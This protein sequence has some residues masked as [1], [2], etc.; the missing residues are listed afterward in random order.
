MARRAIRCI[1][2][3]AWRTGWANLS[4]RR[5]AFR[6]RWT[7][8]GGTCGQPDHGV[9]PALPANAKS[10]SNGSVLSKKALG[11]GL[12]AVQH[13]DSIVSCTA[14][15]PHPDPRSSRV[16][17]LP[18]F[19]GEGAFI[20]KPGSSGLVPVIQDRKVGPHN[21]PLPLVR[22]GAAVPHIE[23]YGRLHRCPHPGAPHKG[24]GVMRRGCAFAYARLPLPSRR[25]DRS[26]I[27]P[28]ERL[29]VQTVGVRGWAPCPAHRR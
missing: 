2:Q 10:R 20:A 17:A 7:A 14:I 15:N 5:P 21:F 22:R 6:A 16:Q 1:G 24:E 3:A 9:P 4:H 8:L 26:A 11:W 27:A 13:I 25:A 28:V 19:L 29:P 18:P 23:V 12:M